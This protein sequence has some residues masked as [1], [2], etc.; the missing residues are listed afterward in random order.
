MADFKRGIKAGVAVAA[1]YL[2]VSVIL[3]LT[4]FSFQFPVITA[5][6]LGIHLELTYPLFVILS[7]WSYMFRGIIF[8]AVFAALYNH[9]PGVTSI[10]K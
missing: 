2:I 4:G 8:G 10:V 9:L 7:I 1:V 6:G 5:A 3:E